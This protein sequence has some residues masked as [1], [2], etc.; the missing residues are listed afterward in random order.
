MWPRLSTTSL[1]Q[2]LSGSKAASLQDGWK[3]ALTAYGLAISNLQRAERLLTCIGHD[4]E[5]LN[6][7]SN[8]G[9]IDWEPMDHPDWL[10]LEIENNILIR[11]VQV[12]IA[13]E[14]I[15][16]SSGANS[17]MQLNMGEGK[18]SVIVPIVAAALADGKNLVRVVVLKPLATQMF[19]L[20]LGK[21]GGL[22]N[23]RI[24]HMPISRS[25][26]LDVRLAGRIRTLCEECMRLGGIL[27]VQPE[28]LLSFEL[29]GLERLL[30]GEAELGNVLIETQRWLEDNSRDILDES[31]EILSVKFELV[32]T[33]GTQRAVEFSPDRW[34]IIQ[35]VLGL[36]S[37][38]AE[39]VLC[40]FPQGLE[41]RPVCPG[42]FPR[43]RILQ[44]GAGDKLVEMIARDVCE[45]GLPGVPV[46]NLSPY[47][48]SALFRFLTDA[49]MGEADAVP[50]QHQAFGVDSMKKSLLLLKGLLADGILVFALQQKRWRVNYG[51]DLSRTMLAVPYRA[52]D[53]PSS[54]AE[55]SHPDATIVL[56]CLSYY[57]GGLSDEQLYT[58]FDKLLLYDYAQEEYD[59]WVKN[60]PML[61]LAFHQLAGVNLSDPAQCTQTV[62]PS[63]RL[64]KSAIDF[65]ISSIVFPKE[66]KEFPHKLSSSGWDLSQAKIHPTTGFSGTNDS[67]YCLP[68]S[69]SQC[70]LPQQL[71]TN[72]AVLDYLLRPENSFEHAIT[73][74]RSESLDA[75]SLLQMVIGAVPPVRVILDVG[76]Q[77]LEWTNEEVAR[78]WLSRVPASDAQATVYF[79][80]RNELSVMSR[81]GLTES[82]MISPFAKQMDLCLVY[83]D[84]AHT[85]G[86]DLKLPQNYR[87]AVT[88][89]PDLTKDRLVQACMR[90]RKL[91]KGQS[92]MFCGPMEVECKILQCSGKT[93]SDI[94]EVADVLQWSISETCK[95][96]RKCIPLWATQ[97]LRSQ[98]H[99]IA[100]S[101]FSNKRGEGFALDRAQ[102][103]LEDEAQS[104]QDRYG[105]G[106][107]RSEERIL[108]QDMEEPRL[109]TRRKELEA[110]RAKCREFKLTS[111]NDAT[112]REEQERE[113][114]PENEVEREVERPLALTPLEHR[115]HGDVKR[116]IRQ[117][118][119]D[120]GSE[121]FQPAFQ[122]FGQTS[123]VE[124]LEREAWPGHLLITTDFAKTVQVPEKQLS[125]SYLRPVHWVV[126]GKS[127]RA[128]H[129]VVLSPYEANELLPS[130]RQAKKVTL[131]VYSPRVNPSV[132]TLEDLSF[133]AIPAVPQ[134]WS[135]PSP[136][137][138]HLN[139]FAGQLYLKSF[140]EYLSVCRFLG[141]CSRAPPDQVRV[142]CDGFVAR[143][144]RPVL[145]EA[146][147]RECPFT[148]SPVAFLRAVMALR[149][150]GQSFQRSHVGKLLHGE[151]LGP[152]AFE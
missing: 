107:R 25:I 95:S 75:E 26:R 31:D 94:I 127:K 108:L 152:E 38:F 64:A 105:F 15:S 55:F 103:L 74:S 69:I 117:G 22:L 143:N 87:A 88:L 61:P 30:S 68:L 12:Q 131:H 36:V 86:T 32:Y 106:G 138:M 140:D 1:L 133:C 80:E 90:M 51:L 67:R 20:L 9:H 53:I 33:M 99:H 85:R 109:Q 46:W 24:F 83:L 18:S 44:P 136:I 113:L 110:I 72:A 52:K 93:P 48:R 59:R 97:G 151:L 76:A 129:W 149:R 11:P 28:H 116:F 148:I 47:L 92:V 29:M 101:E 62:F 50:L 60:A 77:V 96:T 58:A 17:I 2:H 34:L 8:P 23:R 114:S 35:H 19:Q 98:R 6:E 39:A 66:M 104:L 13:R 4:V 150:K 70:D 49:N 128:I 42:G 122:L 14:M 21:L 137:V 54:R 125:D 81:D 82:L 124:W 144:S 45:A 37:R 10:L 16:P 56:S 115:V 130:I 100:W 3:R 118:I 135:A 139:L 40:L 134:S 73:T 142:A 141:L 41:L 78:R 27:L 145:D 126:S 57:Y 102:S 111:L 7:L 132:R 146:M 91:G 121:A 147:A 63:L 5:M 79:D 43:I 119:L 123:A 65:F 120:R 84:E 89:G 112:L 71:H